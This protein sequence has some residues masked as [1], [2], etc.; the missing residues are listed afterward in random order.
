MCGI[1]GIATKHLERAEL[2]DSIERMARAIRHRGP[3]GLEFRFFAPPVISQNVALAHN[4]L[5]IIDVSSAGREPMSNEDGTVWLVFN[6]EIYNFEETRQRLKSRGHR[7]HSQTDAEVI[8]HLYEE[9]GPACVKQL[10]GI[11]AFAILDLKRDLLFLARDPIG[12]KP[13]FYAVTPNHFLFG[14]EIKALLASSIVTSTP[15]WQAISDFLTYLYVPGPR[16]AFDSILQ[17]PPAHCLTLHLLDNSIS[18][19][20]YWDVSR[21][22]DLESITYEKLKCHIQET[23]SAAVKR[24]LVSD[25][26][27][28]VF[29]SGGIDSTIVAGLAKREKQDIQ[30]YTLTLAGYEY[31]YFDETEKA[32]AV[33]RHLRTEHHELSLEFPDLLEMLDLVEFFDQ[34]FAN[35]TSYLMR[36]LSQKAREHITVALCGAGGDELFA[37]YPRASAVRLARDIAWIPRPLLHLGANALSY[38]RD[39]HQT[40]YLRRARK[41]L[42]GLDADFFVQYV[43]WTYFMNEDQKRLIL[44]SR[45]SDNSS[46]NGLHSSVDVLRSAY[47]QTSL[48]D[49]DN[50]VLQMDLKTYLV[51]NILDYTDRMSMA[52]ALEVRVPLLDSAF[53]EMSLNAPF[54]YKIRNRESKAVLV[55][56]FEEFFPLE[57]RNAPK[58]GFN[59]PLAL[60]A[61][62]LFDPYFDASANTSHPLRKRLGDDVGAA[63]RDG[64]LDMNFIQQL[65]LQHRQGK[66]DN[67]HELF[68]CILF[69]VWWRK[70]IKKSQ[71]F[72]HWQT[73]QS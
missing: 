9:V 43:N 44:P 63:W 36:Q 22:K 3:D 70:Y 40:P 12:V 50:R 26:P 71:P 57:A 5:A 38:L 23:L 66:R 55:D 6:G 14:S 2:Q 62:K 45:L 64:I 68:A 52:T 67:A 28:G 53:V 27:L 17:L 1:S 11:F 30:T 46:R 56:A 73:G 33:S 47:A 58:R 60:W 59:A 42:G 20:R 24:Q 32:R 4:R 69:D 13:L 65:R 39:S 29:L 72:I 19:E 37:G 34:P 8:I 61:G 48:Q 49:E 18:L 35:P 41:F 54:A 31:R 7:F 10:D 21:R 25:V 51:D 16:T 15:D